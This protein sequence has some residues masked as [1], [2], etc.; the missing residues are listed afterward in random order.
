M[1]V[2]R[3]ST[4]SSTTVVTVAASS[5]NRKAQDRAFSAIHWSAAL[6]SSLV[7]SAICVYVFFAIFVVLL[8]TAIPVFFFCDWFLN[9]LFI[10]T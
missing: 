9:I 5:V 1:S 7:S 2:R 6:F 3:P 8:F 4:V 10:L